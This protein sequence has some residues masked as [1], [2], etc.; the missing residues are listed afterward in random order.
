MKSHDW[1]SLPLLLAGTVGTASAQQATVNVRVYDYAGLSPAARSELLNR[2]HSILTGSGVPTSVESC[3]VDQRTCGHPEA[4]VSSIIV[5]LLSGTGREARV[6]GRECL[7]SSVAN[8]S[9]GIYASVLVQPTKE[10]AA[11]AS[12]PWQVLLA[13]VA[14]HEIGHLLLGSR[15]HD[16]VGVMKASW[17]LPDFVAMNQSSLYFSSRQRQ[18]LVHRYGFA[19]PL[20]ADTAAGTA[21]RPK[22]S[23]DG[24]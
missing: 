11:D 6:N 8:P 3:P 9:G 10:A 24:S 5:R 17:S 18:K 15:A 22:A 7:G 20:E 19:S 13:Y 16:A 21:G 14:V 23:H 4:A 12:I 1:L 2:V